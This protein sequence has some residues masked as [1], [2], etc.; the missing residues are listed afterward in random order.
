M[1]NHLSHQ[2]NAAHS[3]RAPILR[4]PSIAQ[5]CRT[6]ATHGE[7]CFGVS[8]I[9]SRQLSPRV[10]AANTEKSNCQKFFAF[11]EVN[12]L[13]LTLDEEAIRRRQ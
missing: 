4:E 9:H 6:A 8:L 13:V 3:S 10:R 2:I 7:E 11:C 12:E 5:A 1:S